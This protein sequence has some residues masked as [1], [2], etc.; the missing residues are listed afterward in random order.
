MGIDTLFGRQK[1]K[2]QSSER[3]KNL[4]ELDSD[5]R[6]SLFNL[7]ETTE[8]LGKHGLKDEASMLMNHYYDRIEAYG[9][10]GYNVWPY[11]HGREMLKN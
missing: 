1:T 7:L 9:N 8:I 10:L 4:K 6:K 2:T 11:F 5:Q 3:D